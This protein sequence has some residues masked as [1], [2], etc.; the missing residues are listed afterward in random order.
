MN[1]H[2]VPSFYTNNRPIIGLV[3]GLIIG[4]GLV[5]TGCRTAQKIPLVDQQKITLSTA[6]LQDKIKGGWAGQTIGVSYGGP[7]EFK[8]LGTMVADYQTIPWTDGYIK[9]WF[10]VQPGLFDDL[11]MDLTFVDVFEKQG[12]DAAVD[13]FAN[14]FAHAEYPLWHANQAGRYNILHGTKAPQSG[15]WKNNPHADDIDFQIEADFAGLMSPAMPNTAS[16]ISDKV[17]HIMNYG[18]GWYGGVFVAS[19]YSHAFVSNDISFIVSESL[20]SIPAESQFYQ[21]IHDVIEWHKKYPND[22]K[23]TWFE[24]QKKWSSEV[25]CPDGVFVPFNI[26]AKLNAAYIVIGLLYGEGDMGKTM[27]IATRSGQDADC[28]PASAAGILG[29]M[30][31]Y[32]RIPMLW[33]KN[34]PEVENRKFIYTNI[35]LN[36]VYATSYKHAVQMIERNGGSVKDGV[37]TIT[38][39]KPVPVRFEQSF[40]GLIPVERKWLGWSG[41]TLKDTYTS[42]FEGNGIVVVASISNEWSANSGYVFKVEADI[43]GKKEIV[44]MPY[45]FTTRRTDLLWKYDLPMGKHTL[46]LHLLN[47]DKIGNIVLKDVIIYADKPAKK[48]F[49]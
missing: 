27:D 43:D 16:G 15:Y 7:F 23:T 20:K 28:N 34:L 18:D 30:L 13:S 49:E 2:S 36:D 9:Q 14:A 46:K 45:N 29:T 4:I 3:F 44:E 17:G 31:G 19:M 24:V 39:Q 21:A 6:T 12:M 42:D 35:S 47:P 1:K 22:W 26:D 8:F 11:Y 37:A 5:A 32:D 40:G 48:V 10:D 38:Y 41:F 33:K 25:G